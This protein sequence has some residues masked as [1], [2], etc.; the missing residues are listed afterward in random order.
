MTAYALAGDRNGASPPED[1][2]PFEARG[3]GRSCSASP[4][5]L[6]LTARRGETPRSS[7]RD[8]LQS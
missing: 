5:H 7:R 2:V 6:A 1:G 8:P 4:A 3:Q